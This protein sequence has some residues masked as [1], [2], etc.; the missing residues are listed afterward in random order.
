MAA[1]HR[2]PRG[3]GTH[4]YSTPCPGQDS[5]SKSLAPSTAPLP[6]S[7]Q[8]GAVHVCLLSPS[9]LVHKARG[10]P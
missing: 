1:R 4:L 2:H 6:T 7:M 5:S 3:K 9:L 10:V 8:A